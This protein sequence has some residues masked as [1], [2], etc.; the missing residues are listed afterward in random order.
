MSENM[1]MIERFI[2]E[3][4]YG[5]TIANDECKETKE[6]SNDKLVTYSNKDKAETE[7][8]NK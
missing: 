7:N 6:D 8:K 2:E 3:N 4:F 1:K 5:R